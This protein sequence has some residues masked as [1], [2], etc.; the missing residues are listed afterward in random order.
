LLFHGNKGYAN[1]QPISIHTMRVLLAICAWA[2]P[3]VDGWIQ[4]KCR[5]CD[6]KLLILNVSM[7]FDVCHLH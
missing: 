5:S 1:A 4:P 2:T 3:P 7:N 6:N